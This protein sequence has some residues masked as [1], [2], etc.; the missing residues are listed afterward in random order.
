[1]YVLNRTLTK[2]THECHGDKTPF[3]VITGKKPDLNNLRI[4][5]AHVKVMKHKRKI[6]GKMDTKTWDG[7]NVGYENEGADRIYVP[8]EK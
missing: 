4:F 5:G 3:E 2:S 8:V 7:I 6:K 1:V